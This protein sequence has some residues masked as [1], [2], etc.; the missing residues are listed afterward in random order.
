MFKNIKENKLDYFSYAGTSTITNKHYKDRLEQTCEYSL[1]SILLVDKKHLRLTFHAF[2]TVL[3]HTSRVNTYDNKSKTYYTIQ[4]QFLDIDKVFDLK[5]IL[6]ISS[7]DIEKI[8]DNC[9]VQFYSNDESFYWQGFWEDLAS[10]NSAIYPFNGTHGKGAW[11]QIHKD[12]GGL[13]DSKKRITKHIK[14]LIDDFDLILE[15]QIKRYLK[16]H[17]IKSVKSSNKLQEKYTD[18]QKAQLDSFEPQIKKILSNPEFKLKSKFTIPKIE[19]TLDEIYGESTEVDTIKSTI[20]NIILNNYKIY[21]DVFNKIEK[22]E[23]NNIAPED[24]SQTKVYRLSETV[25]DRNVLDFLNK[26]YSI[27]PNKKGHVDVGR[28]EILFAAIL[29]DFKFSDYGDLINSSGELLEIKPVNGKFRGSKNF[30]YNIR[31]LNFAEFFGSELAKDTKISDDAKANLAN[32]LQD[33]RPLSLTVCKETY[34]NFIE[35]IDLFPNEAEN[36]KNF[37]R[38]FVR[39]LLY[40]L[41]ADDAI[42]DH[43]IDYGVKH[44]TDDTFKDADTLRQTLYKILVAVNYTV[45]VTNEFEKKKLKYIIFCK[46]LDNDIQYIALNVNLQADALVAEFF[47]Q[48]DNIFEKLG[49]EFKLSLNKYS[50]G[51]TSFKMNS[52]L[53]ED[54]YDVCTSTFREIFT[55]N[56]EKSK[57]VTNYISTDSNTQI[58]AYIYTEKSLFIIK[59]TDLKNDNI[60]KQKIMYKLEANGSTYKLATIDD[61]TD[62]NKPK[63]FK[64]LKMFKTEDDLKQYL[65]TELEKIKNNI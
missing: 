8:A 26:I 40:T 64:N 47:K 58:K 14:Q 23:I 43:T 61:E 9:E 37:F 46:D 36:L 50:R 53:V 38:S 21:G 12:S 30:D 32:Y 56:T 39:E 13:T 31:N 42:K 16:N 4:I 62:Y 19:K 7:K 49:I 18:Y 34:N 60:D 57:Y 10:T 65:E 54:M 3:G 33:F 27:K 48:E 29:K 17:I 15:N 44:L 11:R 22:I 25:K 63:N 1:Y 2:P 59:V 5:K 20:K 51:T 35:T 6:T 45:Y 41:L 52:F 55:P 24:I 28:G